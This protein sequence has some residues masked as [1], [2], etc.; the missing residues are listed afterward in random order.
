MAQKTL[1]RLAL[2]AALLVSGQASAAP[3]Q[4][5]VDTTSLAGVSAQLA[6]DLIDGGPPANS[7]MIS[8]FASDGLL[9]TASSTDDVT[10]DFST[11]PGI[12]AL[13]D[14]SFF[15]EYL[16]GITLGTSLTFIFDTSGNPA[17]PGSAPDGFSFF[18]LNAS[19]TAS[20]VSTSD[21]T[22]ADALFLFNIG[23]TDPLV[24]FNSDAVTV[25]AVAVVNG[26]PEPAPLALLMTGLLALCVVRLVRNYSAR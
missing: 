10:G 7:V 14:T 2:L 3:I 23:E 8:D 13:S 21:P 26:V 9:D 11:P 17:D 19:G 15:S 1:L 24:V 16:Q 18:I 4:I 22:G 25:S 12:V 5:T 6:F 20:L